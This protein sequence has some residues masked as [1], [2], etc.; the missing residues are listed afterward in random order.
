[1]LPPESS[2]MAAGLDLSMVALQD[3]LLI[4]TTDLGRL[5]DLLDHAVTHLINQ[6][7][8]ASAETQLLQAEAPAT[9]TRI[10]AALTSAQIALQFQD[11]STQLVTHVMARMNSVS[12]ALAIRALPDEDNN[13]VTP[14]FVERSCPVSQREMDAGTVELF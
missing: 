6:F 13:H 9:A 14:Q 2:S 11:L 5:R 4:A 12:D 7:A 1:V 3:E 8:I 10:A